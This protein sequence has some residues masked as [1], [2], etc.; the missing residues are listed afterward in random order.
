MIKVAPEL[1]QH[2][3]DVALH[4]L[5]PIRRPRTQ[6]GSIPPQ[7]LVRAARAADGRRVELHGRDRGSRG[8][9]RELQG[10]H[11]HATEEDEGV[12]AVS[13]LL[14]QAQP[15]SRHP[16]REEGPVQVHDALDPVLAVSA[17]RPEFKKSNASSFR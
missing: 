12:L 4:N 13:H 3:E 11:P 5:Q 2:S 9:A 8:S 6:H 10:I 7:Q 16:G 15:L 17:S 1:R 14:A